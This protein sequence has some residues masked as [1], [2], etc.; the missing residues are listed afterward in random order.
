MHEA[1]GCLPELHLI[2]HQGR[3]RFTHMGTFQ[4]GF[5]KPNTAC[6]RRPRGRCPWAWAACQPPLCAQGCVRMR[7]S[8]SAVSLLP[9]TEAT[10]ADAAC[11]VGSLGGGMNMFPGTATQGAEGGGGGIRQGGQ[12]AGV[13]EA[14]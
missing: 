4:R 12:G 2:S 1:E 5:L 14:R 9:V 7:A 10:Q 11:R 8:Y 3:G 6:S 13:R